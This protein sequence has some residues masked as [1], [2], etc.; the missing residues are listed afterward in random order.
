MDGS[1]PRNLGLTKSLPELESLVDNEQPNHQ[2]YESL[3][4]S[5]DKNDAS[6]AC[7]ERLFDMSYPVV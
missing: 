3:D 1:K 7:S 5:S 6:A 2:I 4:T